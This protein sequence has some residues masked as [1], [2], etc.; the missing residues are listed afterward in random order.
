LDGLGELMQAEKGQ[1]GEEEDE[2]PT[3]T[4]PREQ[5]LQSPKQGRDE[6]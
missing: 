3:L 4:K 2:T 5:L 1:P 6:A